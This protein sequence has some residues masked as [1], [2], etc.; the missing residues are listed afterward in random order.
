MS[1]QEVIEIDVLGGKKGGKK[2][3]RGRKEGKKG[4]KEGREREGRRGRRKEAES[5]CNIESNTVIL[6]PIIWQV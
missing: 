2:V 3:G 1:Q 5:G 4:E 6:E